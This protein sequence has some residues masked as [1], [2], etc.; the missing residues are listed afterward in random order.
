MKA[1]I[2]RRY[3]ILKWIPRLLMIGIIS[4]AIY[5]G[6]SYKRGPDTQKS[7]KPAPTAPSTQTNIEYSHFEKGRLTY[8]VSAKKVTIQKSGQQQLVDPEFIFYDKDQKEMIS[9]TGKLCHISRDMNNITVFQDTQVMSKDRMMV[10]TEKIRYESAQQRFISQNKSYF[11]WRTLQGFSKGFIYSIDTEQLELPSDPTIRYVNRLSENKKPI[12]MSGDRAFIDRKSGFAFFEGDV[13]VK[14][15]KD[16]TNAERIEAVFKPGGNDLEKLTAIKNVRMKFGRPGDETE[17]EALPV[18]GTTPQNPPKSNPPSMSNVFAADASSAK[19][20]TADV[21]ELYFYPDGSTIRAFHS[22]GDCKF[23]LHT[24][25][26]KNKP[27]EDRIINGKVF[28]AKFNEDGDMQE[29]Q[30]DTDVSVKLQPYGN[31]KKEKLENDQTIFCKHLVASLVP[32]TGEIQQIDFNE[33][34]KHV[35]AERTISSQKAVYTSNM[36]KTDLI[37]KPEIRDATFTITA[38]SMQLLE[39]NSG[40]IAKGN[41]KSEFVRSEGKT[42]MT[43]PFSSPSNQPVYISSE[44]MNWDSKKSEATYTGKAKLWQEKNVITAN[45]LLINDAEKTLSAYEKVHTIFY[46]GKQQKKDAAAGGKNKKEEPKQ[47]PQTQTAPSKGNSQ[48]E[49]KLVDNP[50]ELQEGPISV[51]AGIMN[52]AEKDRVI[53]FERDVKIVTSATKI[54]S[55]KADFF[56]KQNTSD[57]D[58]LYALGNVTLVHEA[59]HGSG[60]QATFFADEQKLV[61]EGNPKLSE[62]GQADVHGR[63]LTLFLTDD[64][65]LIDGQDDGRATTTL[66]MKGSPTPPPNSSKKVPDAGSEDRQ[67]NKEL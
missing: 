44:D 47:H 67:P 37:G 8:H 45:K 17:A 48:A 57:F 59:R 25:N 66:Q 4:F 35:Q 5:F 60:N 43:F 6:I 53:H 28:D 12:W 34:F 15:G 26:A 38:D 9:I 58:K 61:L 30:A 24:F 39:E 46:K 42:P 64:R 63:I 50:Q 7:S 33:N 55:D 19:D 3:V 21:V 65:I 52:Y 41:V 2:L 56:L 18:D 54:N 11:D 36:K 23:V 31:P 51:D 13:D 16:R 29:F 1:T 22:T 32:K 27:L 49:V 10:K 14:Q 62:A 20:L 40:I